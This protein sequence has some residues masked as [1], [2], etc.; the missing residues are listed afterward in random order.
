MPNFPNGKMQPLVTPSGF[1]Y[2]RA[3]G[4]VK[5]QGQ[6]AAFFLFFERGEK[7]EIRKPFSHTMFPEVVYRT[8]QTH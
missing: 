5:A 4:N 8:P 1:S 7:K 3:S 2:D 6:K